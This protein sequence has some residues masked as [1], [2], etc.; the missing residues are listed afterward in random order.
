MFRL[1]TFSTIKTSKLWNASKGKQIPKK[2]IR[3]QLMCKLTIQS[4]PHFRWA[5][6]FEEQSLLKGM[7]R[8][9]LTCGVS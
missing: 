9:F 6:C 8:S 7:N 1:A 5:R 3:V 2:L 4:Y